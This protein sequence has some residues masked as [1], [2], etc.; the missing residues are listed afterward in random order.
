VPNH[1]NRFDQVFPVAATVALN[2]IQRGEIRDQWLLPSALPKMSVGALACHL[3]R[4]V[5]RAAELLPAATDVPPLDSADAH[6]HR[7]AWVMSTSPDDPP[8]DRSADD[9]E[10]VLG[11][12]A[13][14]GR[15]ALALET[16]RHLLAAGL[17]RDVSRRREIAPSRRALPPR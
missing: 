16:V 5:G 1:V 14:A 9:A 2:L 17:A 12:A 13:L 4:Q 10:A 11:A 15:S 8:N 7:A 3:G 6:Y